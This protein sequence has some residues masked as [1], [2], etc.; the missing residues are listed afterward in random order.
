MAELKEI[1]MQAGGVP[2]CKCSSRKLILDFSR[3][4]SEA[5]CRSCCS[6]HLMV[7]NRREGCS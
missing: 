7:R 3:Y 4:S 6:S 2:A 5:R 1:A